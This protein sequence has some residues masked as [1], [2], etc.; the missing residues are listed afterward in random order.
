M[1]RWKELPDAIDHRERQLVVQLRRLK[2]RS[3][4]SLAALAAKTT[5]SSSS[6]ERY[7]NGKKP[8]PRDAVEQL[9]RV[10]DADA[11][12][13][14]VLHEVAAG[15]RSSTQ[16]TAPDGDGGAGPGGDDSGSGAGVTAVPDDG[17]RADRVQAPA[18]RFPRRLLAAAALVVAVSF[19]AGAATG[20]LWQRET[21]TDARPGTAPVPGGYRLGQSYTCDVSRED[22]KL[23]A[24]HGTSSAV[25]LDIN[26]TGW[27]VVEAQCLLRHHGQDPGETDGRYGQRTRESVVAFQKERGLVP[28][29]I[30]GPDTWGELRK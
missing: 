10:C 12:R 9:A 17:V 1:A 24:G 23:Y 28:D 16:D 3:G 2:D 21:S 14:L 19:L 26:S 15:A 4:L 20:V 27:D 25:L 18:P 29:G 6:W 11:T 13:L 22:G 8:V 5:Y 30:V 7:L